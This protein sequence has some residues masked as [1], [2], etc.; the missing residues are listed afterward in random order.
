MTAIPE[1]WPAEKLS[2][3]H[4][5]FTKNRGK[6]PRSPELPKLPPT[7]LSKKKKGG[8]AQG[9]GLTLGGLHPASQGQVL[10]GQVHVLPVPQ[11]KQVHG[12]GG[13]WAQSYGTSHNG[14]C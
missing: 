14:K 8:R 11:P 3:F 7:L 9:L 1:F 5:S 6:A 13:G 12:Q 4:T 2:S 10:P